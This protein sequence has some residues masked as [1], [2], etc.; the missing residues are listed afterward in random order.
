GQQFKVEAGKKLY[1]HHMPTAEAGQTVE[2]GKVLL[3]D[4]DGS[5]VVGAPTVESA[6]VIAEVKSPLV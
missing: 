5:I 4:K 2:F 6:K 3:V 1:V